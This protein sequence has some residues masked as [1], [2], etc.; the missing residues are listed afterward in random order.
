[1]G[2]AQSP[3][4]CELRATPPPLATFGGPA[5]AAPG[6]TELAVAVGVYGE[7]LG[8]VCAADLIGA[9]DW[10]VRW[11]HGLTDRIDLGFDAL[12]DDRSDGTLGGTAKLAMRYQVRKGFRLEGGVG[13]AD[14]GDGRSVNADLAAVIGTNRLNKTWNYYASAR[15]AGSHGCFNLFCAPSGDQSGSRPPGA[16]IPLG[17]IGSTA[18]VSRD[19]QFVMEGG[20]GEIFSR[21]YPQHGLYI[22]ISVGVL[23]NVGKDRS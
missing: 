19:A 9:T 18:R 11:R 7:G 14:S 22:H 23:F 1:M 8:N 5:T 13:T 15:L 2:Q 12:I 10:F 20:L 3:S 6:Y 17:V 21:E 16:L 4:N